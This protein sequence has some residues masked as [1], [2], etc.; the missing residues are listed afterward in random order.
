MNDM[1]KVL[2]DEIKGLR[3]EFTHDRNERA[4][5]A[6]RVTVLETEAGYVR[7]AVIGIA[8]LLVIPIGKALAALVSSIKV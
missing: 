2:Y 8:A 6:E 1:D 4:K 7:K 3:G 5:V